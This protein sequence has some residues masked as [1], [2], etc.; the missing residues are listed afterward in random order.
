MAEKNTGRDIP[1]LIGSILGIV[2]CALLLPIVV[3]N[4]T[5]VAKSFIFP[6]KVPSFMGVSPLIV[7]SGSMEPTI[8]LDDLIFVRQT[9][10]AQLKAGEKDGD[11]IAFMPNPTTIVTHRIIS[12]SVGED[13]G[14]IF[15]T[16]GD[17]NNAPD[18]RPVYGNQVVGRY[19]FRIPAAGYYA[20]FMKEP[21][22][23]VIFVGVP[24]ALFVIY[25]A[26]RRMLYSKKNKQAEASRVAELEA[27]LAAKNDPD[28]VPAA[29]IP[30]APAPEAPAEAP[31]YPPLPGEEDV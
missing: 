16:Q 29:A 8:A 23:M 31:K 2:L 25:D 11:V 13:G 22:G 14:H 17:N 7:M 21:I 19:W 18:D 6:D 5:L 12:V 20:L 24:L 1:H 9:P 15:I 27:A 4:V 3:V 28:A 30:E 10:F 26:V